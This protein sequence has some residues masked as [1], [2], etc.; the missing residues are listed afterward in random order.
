MSALGNESSAPRRTAFSF[1][2]AIVHRLVLA[3]LAKG[4]AN[5]LPDRQPLPPGETLD[6]RH[7][8]VRQQHLQALTH[9]LSI[10]CY[11]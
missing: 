5:P 1:I 10:A 3:R 8:L 4:S 11:L 6:L 2:S 7:L 9:K